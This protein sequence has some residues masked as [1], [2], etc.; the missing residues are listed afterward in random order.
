MREVVVYYYHTDYDV[1]RDEEIQNMMRDF[2]ENGMK[3]WSEEDDHQVIRLTLVFAIF[4][5]DEET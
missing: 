3:S 5:R 2:R 1:H 4:S